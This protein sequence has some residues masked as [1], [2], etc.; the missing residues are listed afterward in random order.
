MWSCS[1]RTNEVQVNLNSSFSLLDR[2]IPTVHMTYATTSAVLCMSQKILLSFSHSSLSSHSFILFLKNQKFTNNSKYLLRRRIY[3]TMGAYY[4]EIEIE[5]MAWDEEKRVYHYPCPCGDRFEISRRQLANYEDIAI[6]PSC[7]LVIR[8]IYDPVR[9]WYVP[10]LFHAS[11][12]CFAPSSTMRMS[13][14]MTRKRKKGQLRRKKKKAVMT[15]TSRMLW[16]S[17][18][19]MRPHSPSPYQPK[20]AI[21]SFLRLRTILYHNCMSCFLYSIQFFSLCS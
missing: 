2:D 21:R 3:S 15:I 16:R 5:D 11:D 14:L 17:L 10:V 7:S 12:R 8:V 9:S 13:L 18:L 4:D 1:V 6:C 19:S 20:Y